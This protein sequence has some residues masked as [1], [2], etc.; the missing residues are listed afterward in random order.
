[1]KYR[2]K[3]K[4]GNFIH[5]LPPIIWM[6]LIF[7]LSSQPYSQQDIRPLLK[8]KIPETVLKERLAGIE[9][10]YAGNEISIQAKGVPGFIEFFI[11]KGAHVFVFMMLAVLIQWAVQKTWLIGI[12][13]YGIT[14]LLTFLYAISDEWHQSFNP[15]RTSRVEDIGIDTL[16]IIIGIMI[17]MIVN[18][19]IKH[20]KTKG[21]APDSVKV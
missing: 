6:W 12:W 16:G 11:R 5:L 10:K 9:V 8:S 15:N 1:M 21:S 20:T 7:T 3:N 4:L 18:R 17:M 13:S 2:I 14:F 19:V